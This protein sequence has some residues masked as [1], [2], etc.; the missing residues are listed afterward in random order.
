MVGSHFVSSASII[1]D[2]NSAVIGAIESSVLHNW[3]FVTMG[4]F[5]LE[6]GGERD[7]RDP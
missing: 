6:G 4:L 3:T 2:A 5:F 1:Q 7:V